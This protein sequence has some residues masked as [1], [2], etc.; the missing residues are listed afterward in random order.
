MTDSE[1]PLA[2]PPQFSNEVPAEILVAFRALAYCSDPDSLQCAAPAR[3]EHFEALPSRPLSSLQK[4]VQNAALN[5]LRN[6]LSGEISFGPEAFFQNLIHNHFE[7]DAPE[8]QESDG[9]GTGE[10]A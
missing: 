10:A 3:S 9:A 7:M 6:Y 1:T 8:D 5:L 2:P 4:G